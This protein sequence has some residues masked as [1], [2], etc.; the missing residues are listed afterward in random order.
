[1]LCGGYTQNE[2]GKGGRARLTSCMHTST[3]H[4]C[5]G[6]P[7]HEPLLVGRGSVPPCGCHPLTHQEPGRG[8]R[9]TGSV[10]MWV[11]A[12]TAPPGYPRSYSTTVWKVCCNQPCTIHG[13]AICT[14]HFSSTNLTFGLPARWRPRRDRSVAS[15][16]GLR[17]AAFAPDIYSHGRSTD[18]FPPDLESRSES[19]HEL[20]KNC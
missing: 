14:K 6:V 5:L 16:S 2:N 19:P 15:P 13:S 9:G 8:L 10:M 17:P 11:E 20:N 3:E 4:L 1:M 7:L 18:K 12:R